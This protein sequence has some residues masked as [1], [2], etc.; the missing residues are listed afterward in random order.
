MEHQDWNTTVFRSHMIDTDTKSDINSSKIVHHVIGHNTKKI[1][2][3]P[4]EFTVSKVTHS[5]RIQIQQSRQNKK[6]TQKQLAHQCNIPESII[7]DYENG[8]IVP[9][10]AHLTKLS[11]ILGTNLKNM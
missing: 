5:L 11:Q 4:E 10:R 3:T 7:R 6:L 1:S 2:D 9:T 8:T